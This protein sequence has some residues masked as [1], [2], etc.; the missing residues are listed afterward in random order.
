MPGLAGSPLANQY[1]VRPHGPY[2]REESV[3]NLYRKWLWEEIQKREG[4]AY[5]ELLR[6][7]ALAKQRELIL[8]C[9]CEP[10]LCHG[11]HHK[12]CN[13]ILNQDQTMTLEA[14]W[15]DQPGW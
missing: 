1:K 4:P 10:E 15:R 7:A 5:L 14:R 3:L 11:T 2:T 6:L 12:E 9:W 13:R 8:S